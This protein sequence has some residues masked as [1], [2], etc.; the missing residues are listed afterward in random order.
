MKLTF[1]RKHR[2]IEPKFDTT[3]FERYAM[4]ALQTVLGAKYDHLVNSDRPDLQDVGHSLGIEVTRSMKENR[5]EAELLVNEL[6]GKEIFCVSESDLQDIRLYGYSYGL[7]YGQYMGELEKRYWSLALPLKRIIKSKVHKVAD[8]F[9]GSFDQFEL[10]IFTK[11]NLTRH[12]VQLTVYYMTELQ[13]S[14]AIRYSKLHIAQTDKLYVCD[15]KTQVVEEHPI[16]KELCRQFY[17][18]AVGSDEKQ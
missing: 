2:M 8:G 10:F 15:L 4:I 3:F 13:D 17:R 5:T 9:Y 14:N 16:S 12:E 7:D 18:K 11:D 6:A 1:C